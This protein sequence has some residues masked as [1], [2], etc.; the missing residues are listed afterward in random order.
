MYNDSISRQAAID[1]A[2]AE[3]DGGTPYDIPREIERLPSV[4]PKRKGKWINGRCSECNEHAPF[5]AMA[6]T[7]YKSAYCPNCGSYN[8]EEEIN[9]K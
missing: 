5:Y 3:L 7:Y 9:E 1:A 2:M 8:G 6:S 4:Q